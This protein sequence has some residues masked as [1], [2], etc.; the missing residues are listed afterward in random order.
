MMPCITDRR[1]ILIAQHVCPCFALDNIMN[2]HNAN[3]ITQSKTFIGPSLLMAQ[4][5]NMSNFDFSQLGSV[6]VGTTRLMTSRN[7]I[8]HIIFVGTT[9]KMLWIH[10][11][12]KLTLSGM[13]NMQ[14][15][16]NRPYKNFIGKTMSLYALCHHASHC[17][18]SGR[19]DASRPFPAGIFI[20]WNGDSLQ[21]ISLYCLGSIHG[22]VFRCT[23]NRAIQFRTS[24]TTKSCSTRLVG[25]LLNI[26][27]ENLLPRN[28][29]SNV[30]KVYPYYSKF[31]PINQERK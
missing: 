27:H 4:T 28:I 12:T 16:W 5:K 9:T 3:F 23:R 26:F 22:C 8:F 14:P 2:R 11:V 31:Q 19:M 13:Q 10:T 24:R 20:I 25:T 7:L 18:V 15:F 17:I 29:K 6:M 21:N 30:S 1:R